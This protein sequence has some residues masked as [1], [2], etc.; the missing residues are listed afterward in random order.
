MDHHHY[1]TPGL[2]IFLFFLFFWGDPD[3]LDSL[4]AVLLAYAKAVGAAGALFG[5]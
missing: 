1:G 2:V 3:L 4:I 5:G